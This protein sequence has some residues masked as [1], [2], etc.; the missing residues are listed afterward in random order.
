MT[1]G[2]LSLAQGAPGC[3]NR[4]VINEGEA[5]QVTG[6]Q[7]VNGLTNLALVEA[8]I[9]N[10]WNNSDGVFLEVYESAAF[11]AATNALP[12]GHTLGYWNEQFHARRR[13]AFPNIPEPFPLTHAHKFTRTET[14]TAAPQMFYYVDAAR[15]Q[16]NGGTNFGVIAVH[17]DFSFTSIVKTNGQ[18][19]FT[20][21]VADPGTNRIEISTNLVNWSVAQSGITNTGFLNFTDSAPIFPAKFYRAVRLGP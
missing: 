6:F 18:I 14:N 3:P 1:C 2:M 15:N 21:G 12:S 8:A 20:L 5:G 16:T 11:T 4:W 19:R 7:T 9:T 10:E 17:S 13:V